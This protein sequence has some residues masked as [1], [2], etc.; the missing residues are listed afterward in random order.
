[1]VLEK[2]MKI[3][4]V[5]HYA[6]P[7]SVSPGWRSHYVARALA[8]AGH[9]VTVWA[10]RCHHWLARPCGRT[11]Q[12]ESREEGGYDFKTVPTPFY[13]GNGWGRLR[14]MLAFS[15]ALPRILRAARASG[16]APE[17]IIVSSPHPF[18]W[19][20][21]ARAAG[22]ETRLIFEERDIWPESLV[23]LANVSPRH[24]LVWY[25]N[26]LMARLARRADGVISLLP[27]T[28]ARFQALGLAPGRWV[29]LPNGVDAAAVAAAAAAGPG[30]EE[31]RAA[32]AAARDAGKLVVLYAGSMGPPN[33]LESVLD[34]ARAPGDKPYK[35][36]L[37]GDGV[38]RPALERRAR[39]EELDFVQFLPPVTRADSW[40]VM[41]AADVLYN[42]LQ[43]AAIYEYGTSLNKIFDY[44]A[45][46]QPIISSAKMTFSP[47]GLSGGGLEVTPGDPAALD[48]ALRLLAAQSP[49]ER[50]ALGQKGRD[51]V[52][53]RHDWAR[54]GATYVEFCE[55]TA[56]GRLNLG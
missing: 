56:G 38:S 28:E 7:P 25:L 31:Q 19:P 8:R 29:W 45:L 13:R 12:A 1:M 23:E 17:L 37:M 34:L 43:L 9:E 51:Y 52:R 10:A 49:A 11:P 5:A 3:W 55:K 44:L 21:L 42:S 14:N 47:V 20:G 24:P 4:Y 6:V 22:P 32:L 33:A 16:S 18:V 50:A 48:R 41:A 46:G 40:R 39:A 30:P 15:L 2:T 53:A 36:F 27:G 35:I 54:L 26:R